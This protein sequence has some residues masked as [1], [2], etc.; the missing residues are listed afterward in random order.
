MQFADAI[1]AL[2]D[3]IGPDPV[4]N[5]LLDAA[6]MAHNERVRC[7]IDAANVEVERRRDAERK[8]GRRGRA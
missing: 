6:V 7:L 5:A 4:A 1:A 3:R 2:R 8:S